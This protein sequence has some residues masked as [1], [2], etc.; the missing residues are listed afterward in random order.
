MLLLG[1]RFYRRRAAWTAGRLAATAE[2][3]EQM[4]GHRTRLA[5]EPRERWHEK[6]D[7]ALASLHERARSMDGTAAW[8][9]GL[10]TRG[11][12]A[13]GLLGL[14]PELVAGTGDLP[15]L[16]VAVGGVLFA[17]QAFQRLAQGFEQ[18]AAAAVSWRQV[19]DLFRAAA[20]PEHGEES[21]P[22]PPPAPDD[23]P[24]GEDPVLQLELSLIHI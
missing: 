20:R 24:A 12:P 8:F 16:A 6:E 22:S 11:W 13:V 15:G 9:R 4:V 23:A 7:G 2:L 17:A 1:W 3:V 5:Q 10:A 14:A 18:L 21:P 19:R